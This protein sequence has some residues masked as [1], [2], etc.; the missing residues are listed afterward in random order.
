MQLFIR[1]LTAAAQIK[2]KK[3]KLFLALILRPDIICCL[4]FPKANR[5]QN[6]ACATYY[7]VLLLT[8][9]T[10]AKS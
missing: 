5:D 3:K 10:F 1:S 6:F 7:Q 8:A 9:K 2:R 4:Y